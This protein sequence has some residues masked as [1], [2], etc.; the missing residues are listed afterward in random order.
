MM[1]EPRYIV[2]PTRQAKDAYDALAESLTDAGGCDHSVGICWCHVVD[3]LSTIERS[4]GMPVRFDEV[5]A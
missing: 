4:L 5:E 2:L 1:G 3:V